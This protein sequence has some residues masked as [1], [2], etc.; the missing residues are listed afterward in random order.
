MDENWVNERVR[1]EVPSLTDLSREGISAVDMH[2]H[3]NHSDAPVRVPD[4]LRYAA[5]KGI[6]IAITD[7]NQVSGSIEALQKATTTLVIPGIEVSALD[8]PHILIYFYSAVDLADFYRT[9][10][11]KKKQ[12]SPYL[13][14]RAST[15]DI[16]EMASDYSCICSAAHPYGYLLFN[17]G[18]GRCVER[19]YL[20]EE[21]ISRFDAI[22]VMS[23]GMPRSENIRAVHMARK[24]HL[25]FTGGT[26]AHLLHDY[27][28]VLTFAFTETVDEFLDAVKDH[29]NYIIGKEKSLFGKGL[30]GTLIAPRYFP[31][32]F[33]SLAIHYE[34][35]VPRIRRFLLRQQGQQK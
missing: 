18:I 21:L 15:S 13:A 34:Q 8:G 4:A 16:L 12:N 26:D 19:N 14:I 6:G 29:Q 33:P 11:E 23:G 30:M 5:G 17:K 27:G 22:E 10:I 28:R 3:T 9:S 20:P 35:N 1:F 2:C 7:H 24:Y 25:G 32:L 31:Y